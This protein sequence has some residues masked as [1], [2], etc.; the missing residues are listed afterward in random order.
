M[1]RESATQLENPLNLKQKRLLPVKFIVFF[2]IKCRISGI[3]SMLGAVRP[4]PG[5]HQ[6]NSK[7]F[8]FFL[9]I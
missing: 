7:F 9:S 6:L 2:S 3:Q 1:R 8:I 4:S 5:I